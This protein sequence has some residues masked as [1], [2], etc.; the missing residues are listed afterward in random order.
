VPNFVEIAQLMAEICQF[1]IFQ[2]GGRRQ[3]GFSNFPIFK[4]QN[5]QEGRNA[6]SCQ[7]SSKSFEPLENA[8]PHPKIVLFGGGVDP[9]NGEL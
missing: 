9:L 5:A 2:N 1:S 8:Y 6:S 7:I 4:S 3:I